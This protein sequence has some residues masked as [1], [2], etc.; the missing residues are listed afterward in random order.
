MKSSWKAACLSGLVYPGAGQ[1]FQK[2][3][4]RGIALIAIATLSLSATVMSAAERARAI[5]A[6]VESS[7]GE[8]DTAT[9][10][11]EAARLSAGRDDR[12]M[13]VSSLLIAGCWVVGVV[14]AYLSGKSAEVDTTP[15][16]GT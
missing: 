6:A 5:L 1:I 7:G 3:Y 4:F 11:R 8:S 2:H 13:A 12:T 14:D 9:V 16:A 10:L 15:P